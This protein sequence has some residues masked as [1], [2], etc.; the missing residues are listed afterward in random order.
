MSLWYARGAI[1]VSDTSFATGGYSEN[2][3]TRCELCGSKQS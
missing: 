3:K 1:V 2:D